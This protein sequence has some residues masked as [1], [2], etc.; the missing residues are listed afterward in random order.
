MPS[1]QTTAGSPIRLQVGISLSIR[2]RMS[3]LSRYARHSSTR[4]LSCTARI[5]DLRMLRR[6]LNFAA[7]RIFD[8]LIAA[9]LL[10]IREF[11]LA[12]LLKRYFDVELP[13]GSQKANWAQ[14][15]L[16]ARMAEY[17]IND[18]RYLLPLAEKLEAELDRIQRLDWFRQSCERAIE[19]AAMRTRARCRM[20]VW[21][22][23]GSGC[24]SRARRGSASRT[25]A[26][27]GEE[28]QKRPIVRHFTFCRM[29]SC[30]NAAVS[31]AAGIVPDYKHFS[32]RRRR[33][34]REAARSA[35]QV[36]E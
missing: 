22:V 11:S 4:K 30:V 23:R 9:R 31:F 34:F 5:I 1:E 3:I 21:R 14:R 7:H 8:T 18:T 2:W 36:P 15:P 33:A 20:N 35:L 10:G 13:K 16:P 25:L 27:A 28:K 26:M 32:H 17:A 19:Q 29:M 12:A 24:V 6:G